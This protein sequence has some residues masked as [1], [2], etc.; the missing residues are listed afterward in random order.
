MPRLISALLL[1]AALAAPLRAH[2][3]AA[4]VRP[5][6]EVYRE[7]SELI[8]QKQ[9][10]EARPLLLDLWA[11]KRTHDVAAS[12][13]QVEYQLANYP[14][15]AWYLAYAVEN[16]PPR[17]KAELEDRY[18]LAY[19]TVKKKV[20]TVIV[21][22]TPAEADVYVDAARAERGPSG[23]LYM[24][25]GNHAIEAMF[26]GEASLQSI[27][28]TAGATH[29][30]EIAVTDKPGTAKATT[31][32]PAPAAPQQPSPP[33]TEEPRQRSL[34]PAYIAG[35][36]AVVGLGL[37]IGFEL[38]AQSDDSDIERLHGE[39]P[40]G[41]C[42]G[43]MP[44]A[45][46]GELKDAN[47]SYDSHQNI[48]ITGFVIAGVGAATAVTYL[49]WPQEK[50]TAGSSRPVRFSAAFDPSGGVISAFGRF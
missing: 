50:S 42:G 32:A 40:P 23:E 45:A 12:L 44:L 8:E 38:A 37:G 25:P 47:E 21:K 29:Q 10:A 48:A 46:C 5:P 3:Q 30:I 31:T 16:I 4:A 11:Q 43:P 39:V 24:R 36:V 1:V 14:Q 15:A 7:A 6:Q 28:V 26:G 41:G 20:A 34:I 17:E 9:W 33:P 18:R 49:L 22:T 27:N 2:A 35:G 13:G 19:D